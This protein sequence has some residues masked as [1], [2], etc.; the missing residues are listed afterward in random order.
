ME[1]MVKI[2]MTVPECAFLAIKGF[3]EKGKFNF[4]YEY[5]K[6]EEILKET[7]DEISSRFCDSNFSIEGR[8]EIYNTFC[9][10]VIHPKKAFESA[11]QN[12]IPQIFMILILGI[13]FLFP[14]LVDGKI[15]RKNFFPFCKK[16]TRFAGF[17]F[18]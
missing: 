14:V 7:F 6:K 17:L 9:I 15:Q 1:S 12:V 5:V 4:S 18:N 3:A 11:L 13:I 2:M 8:K 16:I 10:T